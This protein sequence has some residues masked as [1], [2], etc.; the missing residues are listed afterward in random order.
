MSLTT[1]DLEKNSKLTNIYDILGKNRGLGLPNPETRL[2]SLALSVD[3]V[4][5][6]KQMNPQQ[7]ANILIKK[8]N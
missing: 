3:V 7:L 1:R 6:M 4:E 2:T 8:L 5:F